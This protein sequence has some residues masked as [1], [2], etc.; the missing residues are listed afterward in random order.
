MSDTQRRNGNGNF[1]VV[2]TLDYP[3]GSG[4]YEHL[5]TSEHKILRRQEREGI[6]RQSGVKPDTMS[7]LPLTL[8]QNPHKGSNH[9]KTSGRRSDQVPVFR[10]RSEVKQDTYSPF[11]EKWAQSSGRPRRLSQPHTQR[12]VQ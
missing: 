10:H 8:P 7:G 3:R 5:H 12:F 1:G 11:P 9:G 4:E 2:R 6:F